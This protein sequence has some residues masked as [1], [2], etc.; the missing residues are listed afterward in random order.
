MKN[1]LYA[2]IFCATLVTGAQIKAMDTKQLAKNYKT[3]I[4]PNA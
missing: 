1:I 2:S 3:I 4:R